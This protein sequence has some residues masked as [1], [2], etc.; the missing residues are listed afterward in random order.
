[1]KKIFTT[2]AIVTAVVA[3][4]LVLTSWNNDDQVMSSGGAPAGYANDPGNANKSCTN[5]HADFSPITRPGMITTDIPGSGYY[6]G[7]QYT[8]TATIVSSP[9]VTTFGF[10]NA[11][12][13]AAGTADLGTLTPIGTT[14]TQLKTGSFNY[15][16][17]KYITHKNTSNT[18]TGSRSWTYNWTAPIAGTGPVNFYG[19][20]NVADG[21]G[22]TDLDTIYITS[23]VVN[24]D[25][26]GIAPNSNSSIISV[27][28]SVSNGTF[29]FQNDAMQ[30]GNYELVIYNLAGEIVLSKTINSKVET[31][32]L[33]VPSGLYFVNFK[34]GNS[35][36]VRKIIVQ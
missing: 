27:Y 16:G 18:G 24:E 28:P 8:I 32:N 1:M 2:L 34:T 11:V 15:A 9:S 3:S 20:F 23:M 19:A 6:P 36:T 30:N 12:Q 31:L 14:E 10:E 17:A 35:T 4:N 29:T 25:L 21:T 26:S 22:G 13:N 33:N 7:W 5:C